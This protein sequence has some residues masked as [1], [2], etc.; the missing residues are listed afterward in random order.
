MLF[1]QPIKHDAAGACVRTDYLEFSAVAGP[2][3][4]LTVCG[5]EDFVTEFPVYGNGAV[6]SD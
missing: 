4:L 1:I 5:A 2:L 6:E 3:K